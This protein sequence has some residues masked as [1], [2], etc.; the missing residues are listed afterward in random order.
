MLTDSVKA[1]AA[2]WRFL[3]AFP[4]LWPAG[5]DEGDCLRRAPA[6]FPFVGLVLGVM[7]AVPAWALSRLFPQT[8]VAALVVAALGLF[9]LGLHMDGLAD[10]AD[11]FMSPGR[12][13]ERMLEVMRDS[14]V[15][16]HG[17]FVLALVLIVKFAAFAA[18]P[19]TETLLRAA[20]AA[21]VAGR[22]AMLFPLALLPYARPE[23]L[24]KAFAIDRPRRAL[25]FAVFAACMCLVASLG[26]VKGGL[27]VLFWLAV[28]FWWVRLLR[29]RLGGATGDSYGAVCELAETAVALAASASLPASSIQLW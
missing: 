10:C 6:M 3:T 7:A 22:A 17:A 24:G 5:D 25:A 23:G 8:V 19:D 15:G 11:A 21:P 26:I 2:A 28:C 13:R 20:L 4:F 1:F 27:A 14:R 29:R 18:A 12:T 16:A 9:S